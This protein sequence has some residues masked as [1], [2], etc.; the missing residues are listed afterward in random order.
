MGTLKGTVGNKA[1]PE[2]SIAK[3][4]LDKECLMFCSKYLEGVDTIY[5]KVERNHE[6]REDQGEISVFSCKGRPIGSPKIY[7]L[8]ATEGTYIHSYILNN[9]DEL[10][11]LIK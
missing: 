6:L 2:G 8:S 10:E 7:T 1:Q 5:N 4:Y 11:D 3:R 9:C